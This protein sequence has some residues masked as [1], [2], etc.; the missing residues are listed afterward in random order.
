ME[1]VHIKESEKARESYVQYECKETKIMY[2]FVCQQKSVQQAAATQ[3]ACM[4]GKRLIPPAPVQKDLL[5]L[6]S[7]FPMRGEQGMQVQEVKECENQPFWW[8]WAHTCRTGMWSKRISGR[9][10]GTGSK[11]NVAQ[12]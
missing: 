7:T 8:V 5:P 2:P 10:K 6:F 11:S 4:A 12:G 9:R 1:N 3:I